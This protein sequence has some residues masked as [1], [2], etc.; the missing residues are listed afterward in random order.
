MEH[1]EHTR[2]AKSS[3]RLGKGDIPQLRVL[4][5]HLRI[6][7]AQHGVLSAPWLSSWAVYAASIMTEHKQG[8]HFSVGFGTQWISYFSV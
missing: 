4:G 2:K 1:T 8:I 5:A 6:L 3:L 7:G